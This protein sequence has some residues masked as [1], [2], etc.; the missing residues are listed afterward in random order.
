MGT[1]ITGNETIGLIDLS[2]YIVEESQQTCVSQNGVCCHENQ[3]CQNG[4]FISSSDCGNLS[5]T[6]ECVSPHLPGDLNGDGYVNLQDIQL[7]VNVILEI[8]NRPDIIARADV[9]RNEA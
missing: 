7:N 1:C 3:I 8:E 9:N 2:Q 5:C 6:G 4:T